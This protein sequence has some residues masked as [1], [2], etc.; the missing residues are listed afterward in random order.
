MTSLPVPKPGDVVT[1][2]F[3]FLDRT[4][5]KLRPAVVLSHKS[6]NEYWRR[7][8]F[9]PITG[10][11]GSMEGSIEIQDIAVAGLNRRSYCQGILATAENKDIQRIIGQ[12]SPRDME[13]LRK[14]IRAT[15]AI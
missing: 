7:F 3:M 13:S 8:I 4:G 2:T 15:L 10:S 5:T 6:Y 1:V 14:L 12:L 11:A 9:A